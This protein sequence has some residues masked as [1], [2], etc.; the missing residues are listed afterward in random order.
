MPATV[1]PRRRHV[2][3]S[4]A[5]SCPDSVE[6]TESAADWRHIRT[7]LVPVVTQGSGAERGSRQTLIRV[8]GADLLDELGPQ[9]NLARSG[10][11]EGHDE[12]T[13]LVVVQTDGG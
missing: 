12:V 9:A 6:E 8:L 2:T 1:R 5:S 4:E 11:K 7:E 13:T 10:G 3:N